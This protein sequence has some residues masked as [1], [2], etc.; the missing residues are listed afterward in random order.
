MSQCPICAASPLGPVRLGG[1]DLPALGC[2]AC[3]GAL[4]SLITYR[5]WRDRS[6]SD[7]P[8]PIANGGPDDG[9][10][11]GVDEVRDTQGALRCP[12]CSGLMTKYRFSSEARNHIDLCAHC[13]EVWLDD[14]EWELLGR[15]ALSAKLATIF[16]QPWQYRL[17][18]EEARLRAEARWAETLGDDYARAREIRQWLSGHPKGREMLGYLYLSQTEK[19]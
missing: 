2:G 12:K 17:R 15:F 16:T 1:A 4:L 3:G 10:S 14:G 6:G 13:D 5:D 9:A 7:A 8:T 18:S 19:T 11:D